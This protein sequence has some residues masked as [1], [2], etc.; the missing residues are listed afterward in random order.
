MIHILRQWQ[1]GNLGGVCA[2]LARNGLKW[3]LIEAWK[4]FAP[5]REGYRE[6]VPVCS[7]RGEAIIVLGGPASACNLAEPGFRESYLSQEA[8]FLRNA[9][10]SR[11]PVLGVCLG[12]QLLTVLHGG[13]VQPGEQ[14]TG[15][16]PVLLESAGR[17][18]WL[19]AGISSPMWVY[20]NHHDH[21]TKV[22]P[23]A[24]VLARSSG[25]GVE[26]AS[27]SELV[28]SVQFH[29]EFV[30]YEATSL[31]K[32]IEAVGKVVPTPTPTPQQERNLPPEYSRATARLFDNFFYR[33]GLI[34]RPC[35][36]GSV[37]YISSCAPQ[38][39]CIVPAQISAA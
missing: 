23:S 27:W 24:N 10:E 1:K 21:V 31:V 30:E 15:I 28:A 39:A 14:V 35:W 13:R 6:Q 18:H 7:S 17:E 4:V 11:V 34:G 20:E 32:S 26:A 29:P 9:I 19:F 16:E 22:P 36:H 37:F 25:C 38:H 2:H 8:T 3:H 5:G 12:H 33:A